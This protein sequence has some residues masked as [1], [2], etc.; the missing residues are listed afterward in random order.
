M[1]Y[2]ELKSDTRAY[3]NWKKMAYRTTAASAGISSRKAKI[4][5][6]RKY[7]G[8]V[9]ASVVC[10]YDKNSMDDAQVFA[11]R[12]FTNASLVYTAVN[13][14]DTNYPVPYATDVDFFV[15]QSD[16][17][18][19]SLALS[20]SDSLAVGISIGAIAIILAVAGT[21]VYMKRRKAHTEQTA[22]IKNK[23]DAI[24]MEEKQEAI[25]EVTTIAPGGDTCA[26]KP[27]ENV[28]EI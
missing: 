7:M 15:I 27:N 3:K 2:G 17:S 11:N 10:A 26:R 20:S 5:K 6:V 22:A 1:S 18:K 13:G 19:R 9:T 8:Q 23:L 25:Q 4:K 24:P 14:Y 28:R 12:I 21:V 16:G